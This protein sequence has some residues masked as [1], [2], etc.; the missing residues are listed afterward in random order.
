MANLGE[1]GERG[2]S[3]GEV[4]V[5]TDRGRIVQIVAWHD[6][7]SHGDGDGCE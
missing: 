4:H 2:G 3:W 5:V 7:R 1:I 6:R